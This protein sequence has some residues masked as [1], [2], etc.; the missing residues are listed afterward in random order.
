MIPSDLIPIAVFITVALG[1]IIFKKQFINLT[2]KYPY[3]MGGIKFAVLATLGTQLK[4]RIIS[5]SYAPQL[6]FGQAFAWAL[7]GV[8]ITWGF[9]FFGMLA[10]QIAKGYLPN[11]WL[12]LFKSMLINGIFAWP[13]MMTHTILESLF[14]KGSFPTITWA[15]WGPWGFIVHT[16]IFFWLPAHWFTFS[17][18]KEWQILIA[19]FL[20]IVLGVILAYAG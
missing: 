10:K 17:Q 9:K 2:L 3:P 15:I 18:K 8:A 1:V 11:L 12:A 19:A 20:S 4:E 16:I 5:G 6:L 7:I 14:L 13:M